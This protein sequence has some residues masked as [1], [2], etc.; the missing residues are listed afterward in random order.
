M[1][2]SLFPSGVI[3]GHDGKLRTIPS[4]PG[5]QRVGRPNLFPLR[6]VAEQSGR[7]H[8]FWGTGDAARL[9]EPDSLW[10]AQFDGSTWTQKELVFANRLPGTGSF[11]WNGRT[12][13]LVMTGEARFVMSLP[14]DDSVFIVS[15]RSGAWRRSALPYGAYSTALM[16]GPNGRLVLGLANLRGP[17]FRDWAVI[18]VSH[19]VGPSNWTEPVAVGRVRPPGDSGTVPQLRGLSSDSAVYLLWT[20]GLRPGADDTLVVITSRDAGS[21]WAALPELDAQ[22][23]LNSMRA[24]IDRW[25]RLHVVGTRALAAGEIVTATWTGRR[26]VL[27]PLPF[28]P[29]AV[30]PI[31]IP[32]SATLAVIAP[33]SLY[34]VWTILQPARVLPF[35]STPEAPGP[36]GYP[37]TFFSRSRSCPAPP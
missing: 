27:H 30:S 16:T 13:S 37:V 26:W 28:N 34:F 8:A 4:H 19:S 25:G 9:T 17:S 20:R 1:P 5:V 14:S 31:S 24:T 11:S 32:L 36:P 10:Y 12:E 3:L 15:G 33:D 22:G 23:G 6:A 18:Y 29:L 35:V 7:T 21:S 2:D